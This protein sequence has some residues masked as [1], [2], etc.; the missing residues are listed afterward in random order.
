MLG[1]SGSKKNSVRAKLYRSDDEENVLYEV[2]GQ[3]NDEFV[4]RD[5]RNNKDVEKYDTRTDDISPMTVAA[6]PEQDAWES[7]RAWSDVIKSLR[8]GDMRATAQAKSKIEQAQRAMRKEEKEKGKMWEAKFFS[9]VEH[10]SV[11]EKIAVPQGETLH[12][13]ATNG[14]WR[15]DQEKFEQATMPYHGDT[16]PWGEKSVVN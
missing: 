3:W 5:V 7:R 9:R 8:A 2:D 4:F 16:T 11:F 14:I 10:D 1:L 12:P 6:I 13:Q 15:F